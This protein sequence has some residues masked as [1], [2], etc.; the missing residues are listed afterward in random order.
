[1][2]QALKAGWQ[3]GEA[4]VSKP[5]IRYFDSDGIWVRP[6]RATAIDVL[7]QAGGGGGYGA[8]GKDG[9]MSVERIYAPD[10]PPTMAVTIGRGGRPGGRD[11][12]VLVVTHIEAATVTAADPYECPVCGNPVPGGGHTDACQGQWMANLHG[13][14]VGSKEG[15][16]Q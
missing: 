8:R 6:E 15:G 1:M 13:V 9:Q 4:T 3:D 16:Q 5:D 11:G 10:I 12:Y 7:V 2:A 14:M